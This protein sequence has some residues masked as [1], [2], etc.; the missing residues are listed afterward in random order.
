VVD[1]VW[2]AARGLG[3]SGGPVLEPG[4]GA[5]NFIGHVPTDLAIP[6]TITG[7]ELDPTTARIAAA[8]YPDADIRAIGF[9]KAHL[10]ENHF[11]LAIGNVPF[12]DFALTDRTHNP[13][14]HSIHNHF[15]NKSLAL[16]APGGIAALIT[17]R[18]TL[19]AAN[20]AA[21]RDF[22]D[23]ADLLGAIRLPETA[24]R[25]NAGTDVTTDILFFRRRLPNEQPLDAAWTTTR[26]VQVGNGAA[27]LN[28]WFLAHPED[29]LGTLALT[30]G[31]H[32]TETLTVLPDPTIDLPAAIAAAAARITERAAAAGRLAAPITSPSAQRSPPPALSSPPPPEA[33]EGSFFIAADGT[34]CRQEFGAA[35]PRALSPA[36]A[37]E[38]R[39]LIAIRDT[40]RTILDLQ[41]EDWIPTDDTPPPW[42]AA[43]QQL[44]ADHTAYMAAYGPINRFRT[45]RHGTDPTTGQ[46]RFHRRNPPLGGFRKDPDFALVCSLERFDDETQ[47]AVQGDIFTKRVVSPQREIK[48][49]DS[50][51]DALLATLDQ[52]GH[53]DLDRIASLAG[54]DTETTLADIA[55]LIY[56]DPATDTWQTADRYLSGNVRQKLAEARTAATD[57]PAFAANVTALEKV[58]PRDLLPTEIDARL[59]ATWIPPEDIADFAN[60]I[61]GSKSI[62]VTYRAIDAA[63]TVSSTYTD[64]HSIPATREWGTPRRHALAL[65]EDALQQ[66]TP[67]IYDHF[68]NGTRVKNATATLAAQEKLEALH[69][70]FSKWVWQDPDRAFRLVRKYNETFNTNVLGTFDGSH[71]TLPGSS[72][73]IAL[74][75]HQKNAIWRGLQAGSTLIGHVVGAGKT[76]TA[77]ALAMESRRLGLAN[78]PAIVVP[79][80][81][82]EQIRREFLQLYP[83]A[84]ILVAEKEALDKDHRKEFVARCATGDWD[85]VIMTHRGLE[86]IPMSA[87]TRAD[88]LNRAITEYKAVLLEASATEDGRSPTVKQL[89][90]AVT[91]LTERRT[92]LRAE[93]RKDDGVNFERT[94]IDHIIVDE[95]HLFK[96]LAFATKMLGI[97]G[98]GSQ[99]AE[100]LHMKVQYLD[101]RNPGRALT[102]LTGT[103]ITNTLAEMFTLQRYFAPRA[104]ADRGISHFDSW[105]ATFGRTVTQLELAP[106]GGSYRIN[107]RFAKFANVPELIKMFREFADIQTAD[108]LNLPTPKLIG[109]KANIVVVPASPELKAYIADLVTRAEAIKNRKVQ[110]ADDNMLAVTGDGRHAALDMRL[111]G[112]P[113]DPAGGKIGALVDNVAGIYEATKDNIYLAPDGTQSSRRGALQIIF[114][115]IATPKTDGRFNAYDEI[116]TQLIARGLPQEAVRFVHDA[117]TDD[118]K[119]A[120][121][122]DCRAGKVAVLIG[123]TEKMGVGTNVQTRLVHLHHLDAPW[124][125]ADIEQREGRILRQGNQNQQVGITRYVTEGSFDVYSWQGLERK[126]RFIT[127]VM[128]GSTEARE[129]DDIDG[130]ALT[131]AEVKAIATGNPIIMEKAGIDADVARLTRLSQAHE[132]DE[133]TIRSQ[134]RSDRSVIEVETAT[135]ARIAESL[136]TLQDTRGNA[137]QMNIGGRTYTARTDAG[138]ALVGAI[139]SL[140]IENKTTAAGH[141]TRTIGTLAG[142]PVTLATGG[143]VAKKAIEITVAAPYPVDTTVNIA[144][145]NA[146]SPHGLILQLEN[147]LHA[148]PE[149]AGRA[150]AAITEAQARIIATEPLLTRQF[151]H[152]DRLSALKARQAEIEA[153]LNPQ[154]PDP[155]AAAHSTDGPAAENEADS[156]IAS[157]PTSADET[158]SFTPT[159]AR[160]YRTGRAKFADFLYGSGEHKMLSVADFTKELAR[161]ADDGNRPRALGLAHA[162]VE[163]DPAHLVDIA[164]EL[165]SRHRTY[166]G[167]SAAR[168]YLAHAAARAGIAATVDPSTVNPDDAFRDWR[169]AMSASL[170]ARAVL[171]GATGPQALDAA[172]PLSIRSLADTADFLSLTPDAATRLPDAPPDASARVSTT[173]MTFAAQRVLVVADRFTNAVTKRHN[174]DANLIAR[175]TDPGLLRSV[176]DALAPDIQIDLRTRRDDE[177]RS[178]RTYMSGP[179]WTSLQIPAPGDGYLARLQTAFGM[180]QPETE[181]HQDRSTPPLSPPPPQAAPPPPSS[182]FR[183]SPPPS[184]PTP[185]VT[186]AD[187]YSGPPT[188]QS[189]RARNFAMDIATSIN[190]GQPDRAA[191]LIDTLTAHNPMLMAAVAEHLVASNANRFPGRGAARDALATAAARLHLAPTPPDGAIRTPEGFAAWRTALATGLIAR[192]LLSDTPA[193]TALS[194]L[195]DP[196]RQHLT[197]PQ[198]IAAAITAAQHHP[199]A[200]PD[201]PHH[202]TAA[203][204]ALAAEHIAA[205]TADYQRLAAAVIP[206][207]TPTRMA[208]DA[209]FNTSPEV[210]RSV[211]DTLPPNERPAFTA[212][213]TAYTSRKA[214]FLP[215]NS[216]SPP[217]PLAPAGAGYLDQI[218]PIATT[219]ASPQPAPSSA[220]PT[221][222]S[223]PAPQPPPAIALLT[224]HQNRHTKQGH[225]LFVARLEQRIPDADFRAL[226]TSARAHGG[227]YSR[228][229]SD[230]A[231]PGFHFRERADAERFQT[232][233]NTPIT[234]QHPVQPSL[235]SP[236]GTVSPSS[237]PIPAEVTVV[238][239]SPIDAIRPNADAIA[240][241]GRTNADTALATEPQGNPHLADEMPEIAEA[242]D[243]EFAM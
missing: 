63:W 45:V 76:F 98:E 236:A 22:A 227:T 36:D 226:L 178:R 73:A 213:L 194:S 151:E 235:P 169:H 136:T 156:E 12:G 8:L 106:D 120:L 137:F 93:H 145:L 118:K 20:A 68:S 153:I 229:N 112:G 176:I 110:P 186:I 203:A 154:T 228:Y 16:T 87:A 207:S 148:L 171:A 218:R 38:V 83:G 31:M 32:A 24:F 217:P 101:E 27:N 3:F 19:D 135:L 91:R 215:K 88:Y 72:A 59:G 107:T 167:H 6:T 193:Q 56:R 77:V 82:L 138:R 21:R 17:S 85:A 109:G 15:I 124:R 161:A 95:L 18:Y 146:V 78:K 80:H 13:A 221:P 52:I 26:R 202:A 132:H 126:A 230:G 66:Q 223:T 174:Y 196:V 191:A 165:T 75:P 214:Q 131:F 238:A 2:R 187:F 119:A 39:A 29:V 160:S 127:Q 58:Q 25:K 222:P 46:D 100:D 147:R 86:A 204:Q 67:Q 155:S 209:C 89:E 69:T 199:E 210:L 14:G 241:S 44:T 195:P 30:K 47:K 28:A 123:S 173:V 42:Q 157:I 208:R 5:G 65:L 71:L 34:I 200:R 108:M 224:L 51:R 232:T 96:R 170:F 134:I 54:A 70:R 180:A 37:A 181:R 143:S 64:S 105:A 177:L 192:Q 159:E 201:T 61:L 164:Q 237:N 117:D 219:A 11:H 125:P 116:R 225:L 114:S 242:E 240:Q 243:I 182:I 139:S 172:L 81:M 41:S 74:N 7:V 234:A 163:A 198:A 115:D 49:V 197:N 79:N 179:E 50:P 97:S 133:W 33:K 150:E 53:V 129:I 189:F 233:H 190:N 84:K 128:T 35:V 168:E 1:A 166:R 231:I 62:G 43:Q 130:Q 4:C 141:T 183:P 121:F 60:E 140:L 220:A 149:R 175:E 152:S 211:H 185:S 144:D 99:R 92:R 48:G 111:R 103:P 23:R 239:G 162:L 216:T 158:Q 184:S 9:E 113:A 55:G 104:L 122:A 10:P 206:G 94:G 188:C 102:G 57:D 90:K 212:A 142:F 40:A 205:L